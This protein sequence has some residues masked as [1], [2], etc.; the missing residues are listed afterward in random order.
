[1]Y[2]SDLN[3]GI[4]PFGLFDPKIL[5]DGSVFRGVKMEQDPF[6]HAQRI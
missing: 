3:T 4:D 5:T 1:M 6:F 2:A